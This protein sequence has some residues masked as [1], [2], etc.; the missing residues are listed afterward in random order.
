MSKTNGVC[1]Q[2]T[3]PRII[4]QLGQVSENSSKPARSEHWGVF[5]ERESRSYFA[6]D[7]RHVLP[8]SASLSI[9]PRATA[10]AANVLARETSRN[11][12]NNA[13]PRL[14]VKGCHVIPNGERFQVA[15][16]LSR[17]KNACCV[18]VPFDGANCSPAEEFAAEYSATSA[19]EKSQ[20]IH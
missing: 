9:N 8:H 16:V 14:A 15:V 1:A 13:S 2:T 12:V 11:H 20:L 4:P 17:H 6:N 10:G 3:P 18:A 5:H 7:A 19:R